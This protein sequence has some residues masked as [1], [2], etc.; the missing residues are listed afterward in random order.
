MMQQTLMAPHKK[1]INLQCQKISHQETY[2]W[3]SNKSALCLLMYT[4]NSYVFHIHIGFLLILYFNNYINKKYVTTR[5]T[6]LVQHFYL[7]YVTLNNALVLY[8]SC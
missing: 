3:D 8:P 2:N 6:M 1:K 4:E 7:R 5:N